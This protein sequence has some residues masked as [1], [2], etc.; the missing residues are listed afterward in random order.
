MIQLVCLFYEHR[1]LFVQCLPFYLGI[2]LVLHLVKGRGRGI[3]FK[4]QY[5]PYVWSFIFH[6]H[7]VQPFHMVRLLVVAHMGVVE[8]VVV[9]VEVVVVEE[10]ELVQLS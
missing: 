3:F 6:I 2:V 4:T 5:F 9:V 8:V 7:M 10:L 1:S